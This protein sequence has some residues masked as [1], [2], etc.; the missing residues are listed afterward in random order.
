MPQVAFLA[1]AVK[2]GRVFADAHPTKYPANAVPPQTKL[3]RFLM[4]NLLIALWIALLQQIKEQ[5][6]AC[7]RRQHLELRDRFQGAHRAGQE[8]QDLHAQFAHE[9]SR[10]HLASQAPPEAPLEPA[11][12]PKAVVLG[13]PLPLSTELP[14]Q[15][16]RPRRRQ[17][18]LVPPAA[19]AAATPAQGRGLWH[20]R[21]P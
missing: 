10:A 5:G 15:E 7:L 16:M 4:K 6:Y 3:V 12:E 18:Q 21:P 17:Q 2:H 20:R 9:C 14:A 11:S 19:A 8:R 13:S 1:A